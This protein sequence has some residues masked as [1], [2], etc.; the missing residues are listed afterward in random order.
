M[1]TP[2]VARQAQHLYVFQ[3]SAAYTMPAGNRPW[4]PG[5]FEA[6]QRD[7]DSIRAVQFASPLGAARF[8]AVAV[9]DFRTPPPKILETPVGT[10][11]A[12]NLTKRLVPQ[13]HTLHIPLCPH[14]QWTPS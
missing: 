11:I 3:R 5:E 1:A 6:L 13:G 8:G 14:A 12:M 2:V 10:I 9:G 7:Y 4:R